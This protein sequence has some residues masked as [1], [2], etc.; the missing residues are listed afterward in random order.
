[1]ETDFHQ[2]TMKKLFFIKWLIVDEY[3]ATSQV[4]KQVR[5]RLVLQA[6]MVYRN[7][8]YKFLLVFP[9][10]EKYHNCKTK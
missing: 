8:F 1:M 9:F 10:K 7:H 4:K 2:T 3:L 6:V 5:D